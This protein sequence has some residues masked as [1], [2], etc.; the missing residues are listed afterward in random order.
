MIIK[1]SDYIRILTEGHQVK[2]DDPAIFADELIDLIN[3]YAYSYYGTSTYDEPLAIDVSF[4]NIDMLR[5]CVTCDLI[6]F[7]LLD[8]INF[9]IDY[10]PQ[11]YEILLLVVSHAHVN[12]KPSQLN[13]INNIKPFIDDNVKYA[14]WMLS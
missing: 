5:I 1:R 3:S 4:R 14:P 11:I 13:K 7:N 6:T 9:L 8:D 10:A 2:I 12:E